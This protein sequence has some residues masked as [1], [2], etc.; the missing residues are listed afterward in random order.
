VERKPVAIRWFAVILTFSTLILIG[1]D[2][3]GWNGSARLQPKDGDTKQNS[4]G[5]TVVYRNGGWTLKE[6][7]PKITVDGNGQRF[8]FPSQSGPFPQASV[9]LDTTT[10]S[11]CKTYPWP[12]REPLPRGLPI[13][14]DSGECNSTLAK[15]KGATAAYLGYT[16]TF[17]GTQ[18]IK[19]SKA[20]SYNPKTQDTDPW[21]ADQYD[22]L[23]L[24]S[25]EEKH[26]RL[27]SVAQI[28]DV[29]TKFGVSYQVALQDAKNQGYEV[30]K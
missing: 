17:D 28:Q 4:S 6:E 29:A 13:C 5:D 20:R 16:Y 30:P 24:L 23:G 27:L 22:P 26:K 3:T 10:G 19:G 21:S 14:G 7:H 2:L 11:L 25:S 1:C 12:D 15:L 9:A 18:W 8:V